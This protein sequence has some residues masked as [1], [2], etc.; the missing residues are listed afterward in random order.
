M[1]IDAQ[2]QTTERVAEWWLRDIH[3]FEHTVALDRQ[4]IVPGNKDSWGKFLDRNFVTE[5]G[6]S[7]GDKPEV[8]AMEAVWTAANKFHGVVSCLH[9]QGEQTC[10]VIAALNDVVRHDMVLD[11]ELWQIVNNMQGGTKEADALNFT[12]RE[13]ETI[14]ERLKATSKRIRGVFRSTHRATIEERLDR[15]IKQQEDMIASF[16]GC[17]DDFAMPQTAYQ[18]RQYV[19][20]QLVLQ[21]D[22]VLEVVTPLRRKINDLPLPEELRQRIHA[23]EATYLRARSQIKKWRDNPSQ[24]LGAKVKETFMLLVK[25]GEDMA[26]M[27]DESYHAISK[28]G[29]IFYCRTGICKNPYN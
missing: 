8:K 25:A 23:N 7:I 6:E 15:F 10:N 12:L 3:R 1:S 9:T 18:V 17:L 27:K 16:K 26:C 2:K 29:A 22:A 20:S 19:L 13:L 24:R 14:G 4:D 11:D 21:L 28:L 5:S